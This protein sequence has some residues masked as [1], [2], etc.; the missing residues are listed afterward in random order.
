MIRDIRNRNEGTSASELL[1]V[2][3]IFSLFLVAFY[4]TLDVGMKTWKIGEVRSDLQTTAEIV[5]K[6]IITEIQNSS[7][8]ALNVFYDP[9]D[10]NISAYLCFETPIYD[11][12]I[13]SDPNT[14]E[15]LW[16]GHVLY[17]TLPDREDEDYNTKI[18]YR[19]Y[20]PHNNTAP[21]KST[22][23]TVAVLLEDIDT[24]LNDSSASEGE[25]IKKV[26]H[27]LTEV[28]FE[29]TGCIVN[30]ELIFQENFRQSK[31]A[32]VSFST[33]RDKDFGTERFILKS[34]VKARN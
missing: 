27:K 28:K 30:I 17:F 21:Y 13:Q 10:S 18:L 20:L 29:H 26:C 6:R 8:V 24:Y 16:Q 33:G 22:D 12:S 34:S 31:D 4:A 7:A 15:L 1:V 23:R 11:G 19:K 14:G 9:A 2:V 5:M 32:K 3:F 25:S